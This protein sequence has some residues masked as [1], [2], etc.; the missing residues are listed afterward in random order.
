MPWAEQSDYRS[1]L[2]LFNI[3]EILR[4]W[5]RELTAVRK[6]AFSAIEELYMYAG[7]R[8]TVYVLE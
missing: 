8:F 3:N 6:E 1:K 7:Y 4:C 5:S 2:L